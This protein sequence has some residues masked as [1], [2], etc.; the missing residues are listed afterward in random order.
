M[1]IELPPIPD[2]QR[3]PLV[4]QLLAIIDQLVQRV[5]ELEEAYQQA[6]DENAVLKG[7]KPK[8]KIAPSTLES[9]PP[10]SRG[11][12]DKRPGS[13]KRSK[14]AELT[15]HEETPVHIPDAELPAGAVLIAYEPYVVQELVITTKNTRYWRAPI[16]H[17]LE[18]DSRMAAPC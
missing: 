9:P 2:E 14:T 4:T 7:Q 3:T 13:E 6:R 1:K 10:K 12:G 11:A 15:I 17:T 8:P 5:R 18:G 16:A